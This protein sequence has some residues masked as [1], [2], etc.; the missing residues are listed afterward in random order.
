M[1]AQ[2]AAMVELWRDDVMA[3][4]QMFSRGLMIKT[5]RLTGSAGLIDVAS[6]EAARPTMERMPKD[7]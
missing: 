4:R 7:R 6:K 5:E 3:C 2:K 1:P